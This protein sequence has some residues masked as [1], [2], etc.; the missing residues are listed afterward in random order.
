MSLVKIE[1]TELF[2]FVIQNLPKVGDRGNLICYQHKL[3]FFCIFFQNSQKSWLKMMVENLP[4]ILKTEVVQL[5]KHGRN[6]ENLKGI[7]K[8]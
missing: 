3:S 7:E 6:T 5:S 2:C 1:W 8:Y 4:G